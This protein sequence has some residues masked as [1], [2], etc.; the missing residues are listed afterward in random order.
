MQYF[1]DSFTQSMGP[2][3][4]Y[5]EEDVRSAPNDGD[6]HQLFREL[7]RSHLAHEAALATLSAIVPKA[8]KAA[9]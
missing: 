8:P 2:D 5:T 7:P 3:Y 6:D 1:Y 4:M 9:P